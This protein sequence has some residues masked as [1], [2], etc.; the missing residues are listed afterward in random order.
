MNKLTTT[1]I[2]DAG[3]YF[4]FA[5]LKQK[6]LTVAKCE[7]N[8]KKID[9]FVESDS[10]KLSTLQVKTKSSNTCF[11][12]TEKDE[13]VDK[14][15]FYVFVSLKESPNEMPDFYIVPSKIVGPYIKKH[16]EDY[17]STVGKSGKAHKSTN[18]RIFPDTIKEW[19]Y[20]EKYKDKWELLN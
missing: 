19:N 11:R 8:Q 18:I 14:N 3:E 1:Q 16:N 13:V 20:I 15:K 10:G 2:G 17:I 4:A 9:F 7:K 5:V 6:G 12:L